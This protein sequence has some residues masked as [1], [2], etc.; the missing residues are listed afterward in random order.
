MGTRLISSKNMREMHTPQMAMRPAEW[1]RNF[2]DQTNQMAY[3]L[4]W[5][6]QDFRGHHI[7]NHGGA[8]DGFRA[9]ITFLP[10]ERIGVI[11]LANLGEDNMPEALRWSILDA[12][13]G[14]PFKDWNQFLIARGAA[15]EAGG[16]A[17][18]AA[19]DKMRKAGTNPSLDLAAYSGYY[20]DNAYG[21]A[22]VATEAGKLYV[23]WNG[24]RAPLEHFH[25]DTFLIND[26]RLDGFVT[27]HLDSSGSPAALD[28][29]GQ[30]FKRAAA[31]YDPEKIA[32]RIVSCAVEA[33]RGRACHHSS[34]S[35]LYGRSG[36]TARNG[37]TPRRSEGRGDATLH[38]NSGVARRRRT[39]INQIEDRATGCVG[40]FVDAASNGRPAGDRRRVRATGRLVE[41]RRRAA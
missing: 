20:R 1:G 15:Q 27:F 2:T 35:G 4:G 32:A 40:L 8:I 30:S 19:R 41:A 11:V 24:T 14:A 33:P 12:V 36:R 17:A 5:F 34:G 16:A 3:G 28:F 6:L 18:I 31:P 9:N 26:G 25:Y 21:V 22:R 29:L 37:H 13:F 7:V 38:R 23:D 10:N 39:G